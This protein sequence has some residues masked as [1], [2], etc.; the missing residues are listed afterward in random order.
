MIERRLLHLTAL[1]P[2]GPALNA[3]YR[4]YG[5]HAAF[6]VVDIEEAHPSDARQVQDAR[7]HTR[8]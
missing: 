4:Q 6:Y 8:A 3:L 2:G 7:D 1:P 5:A